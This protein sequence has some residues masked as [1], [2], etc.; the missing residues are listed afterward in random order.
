M[1]ELILT[2]KSPCDSIECMELSKSNESSI[3]LE[4]IRIFDEYNKEVDKL[5]GDESLQSSGEF[6][7]SK[8]EASQCSSKDDE[9]SDLEDSPVLKL[10]IWDSKQT[11][12]DNS[13]DF[14]KKFL[15]LKQ[16]SKKKNRSA[17]N[18]IYKLENFTLEDKSITK[19]NIYLIFL[20]KF[21]SQ[22]SNVFKIIFS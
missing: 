21:I 20:T 1:K 14:N 7:N 19:V 5:L 15:K 17:K 9:T 13:S 16:K 2:S 10:K 12:R 11:R 4:D 18:Y 6:S 22:F 3:E 8:S